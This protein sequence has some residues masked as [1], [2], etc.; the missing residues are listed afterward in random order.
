M[1]YGTSLPL[2]GALTE[3]AFRHPALSCSVFSL[4]RLGPLPAKQPR[5][6]NRTLANLA[7]DLLVQLLDLVPFLDQVNFLFAGELSGQHHPHLDASVDV[8][9]QFCHFVGFHGWF[10]STTVLADWLIVPAYVILR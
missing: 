1:G 3:P 2:A 7:R 8:Q 5:L 6:L 4:Q 10:A 9:D